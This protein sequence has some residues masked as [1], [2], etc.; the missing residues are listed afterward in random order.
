MEPTL[1]DMKKSLTSQEGYEYLREEEVSE[2]TL[3]ELS[4]NK[5]DDDDE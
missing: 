5:G 3:A 1:K 2:D 4:N